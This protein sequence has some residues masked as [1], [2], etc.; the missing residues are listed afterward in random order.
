MARQFHK[1]PC[2]EERCQADKPENISVKYTKMAGLVNIVLKNNYEV[3]CEK[4]KVVVSLR[5]EAT[6]VLGLQS[7]HAS[8]SSTVCDGDDKHVELITFVEDHFSFVI[9]NLYYIITKSIQIV[10]FLSISSSMLPLHAH[11][12]FYDLPF[13]VSKYP[14]TSST[15]KNLQ[16]KIICNKT[17][18]RLSEV[19]FICL[20]WNIYEILIQ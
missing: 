19:Q 3:A 10:V 14:I 9:R 6:V 2:T 1:T 18:Q 7:S 11:S 8:C 5:W 16:R 13:L 12:Y 17:Q 4:T 20:E 15:Q